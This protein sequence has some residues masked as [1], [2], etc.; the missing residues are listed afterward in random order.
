[1]WIDR[2]ERATDSVKDFF[3]SIKVQEMELTKALIKVW[4]F[5]SFCELPH[6]ADGK[7]ERDEDKKD[8]DELVK[9]YIWEWWTCIC[10]VI[11]T[12][13]SKE[14]IFDTF[15]FPS[16][17]D[18]PKLWNVLV[19]E[20]IEY[21]F[22]VETDFKIKDSFYEKQWDESKDDDIIKRFNDNFFTNVRFY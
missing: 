11:S 22:S 17:E 3:N 21:K 13:Q 14:A 6:L 12:T 8:W 5:K 19:P 15:L 4:Q 9:F 7:L 20:T 16:S 10:S 18:M 1:M 2:I